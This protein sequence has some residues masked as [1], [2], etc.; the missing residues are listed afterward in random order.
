M[1][2]QLEK[3]RRRNSMRKK[4]VISALFLDYD[5][6]ISPIGVSR[7]RAQLTPLVRQ[8]LQKIAKVIPI[9]VVTTKDMRFIQKRAPF[10][11][12]WAPIGGV[13]IKIGDRV[14]SPPQ[15][16][17]GSSFVAL[18][19][20]IETE[21]TRIDDSIYIE[22]KALS[23]GRLVAFCVD[24]RLAKDWE[25]ARRR[26][27]T[28]VEP[29]EEQ[30]FKVLRYTG[31]PYIDIYLERV[32]KGQAFLTLRRE[33]KVKGPIMYLGDSELDNPAFNLAEISIGVLHKETPS[34]LDCEFFVHFRD[35]GAFFQELW[36]NNL[37]F[38]SNSRWIV[39]NEGRKF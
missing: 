4:T 24:W 21:V 11:W 32:D 29:F 20:R 3:R 14:L 13:E 17:R 30:G 25:T 38:D 15:A 12:A 9:A 37:T 23:D 5:G 7:E 2:P 27:N 16:V 34:K 33:L 28:L 18:L 26:L 35:I 8:A 36:R 39:R 22:R 19:E 31:R 1:S 10:A 6:T